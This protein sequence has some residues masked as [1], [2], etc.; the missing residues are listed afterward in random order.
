[1][2]ATQRASNRLADRTRARVVALWGLVRDGELT[3]RQFRTEAA[4]V[5]AEANTAGVSLADLGLA[6]EITRA[7]RTPTAPL[8]L[9]PNNVQVDQDRMDRDLERI[10]ERND[11]PEG[12]LGDWA[13]SEPLLT[14]ATAVQ[15]GMRQRGIERWV[16]Q[17]SGVSCP[18][19]TGWADGVA[20][21][22]ETP[23]ARHVGCD[24]IQAPVLI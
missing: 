18:L 7:L 6:A 2:Q 22:V 12:E 17:L 14:I 16:R 13:A 1:M 15:D 21:S 9:V 23:M 19:C 3:A 10:L 5:V 4:A 11:D 20:R 8:G 24:C